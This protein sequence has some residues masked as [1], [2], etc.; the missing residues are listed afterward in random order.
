MIYVLTVLVLA[1]AAWQNMRARE[2]E[3]RVE[4]LERKQWRMGLIGKTG[5]PPPPAIVARWRT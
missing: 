4:R 1:L 2:L 5:A 3:E